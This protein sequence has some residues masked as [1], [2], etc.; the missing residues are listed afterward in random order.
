MSLGL[1]HAFGKCQAGYFCR[2]NAK[3]STPN[4]GN[5]AN[6]CPVGHFCPEMTGE[7]FKCPKGTYG[8]ATGTDVIKLLVI[9]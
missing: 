9:N 4:Q 7:P 1:S 8:N 6:I 5:D 2:R 3:L